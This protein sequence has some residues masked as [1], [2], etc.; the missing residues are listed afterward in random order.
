VAQPSVQLD[1][2]LQVA[3]AVDDKVTWNVYLLVDPRDDN[4]FYVG[5][6]TNPTRRGPQHRTDP[7]SAAY[8]RIREIHSAGLQCTMRV[9]AKCVDKAQARLIEDVLVRVIAPGKLLNGTGPYRAGGNGEY[10]GLNYRG[11]CGCLVEVAV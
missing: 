5:I 3:D 8:H 4:P 7:A 10:A 9:V 11:Y 2:P 6:T 1:L